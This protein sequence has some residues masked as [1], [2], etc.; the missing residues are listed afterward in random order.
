[1][2]RALSP[3]ALRPG[4]RVRHALFGVGTVL[5]VEGQGD[6]LKL[7]VSF[8]GIGA[9][10]LIARYA[11]L[12]LSEACA[13][14]PGRSR[15][16]PP[17]PLALGLRLL[18]D[19]AADHAAGPGRSAAGR[20]CAGPSRRAC[21]CALDGER[22]LDLLVVTARPA[23]SRSRACSRPRAARCASPCSAASLASASAFFSSR[24]FSLYLSHSRDLG[25]RLAGTFVSLR[26]PRSLIGQLRWLSRTY[27]LAAFLLPAICA[28]ERP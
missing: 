6:D 22:Q 27:W 19:P 20:T 7:T 11:G 14:L 28:V 3:G 8:S 23:G 9:K 10:R 26:W 15:R 4:V 1:M 21:G 17:S 13:P 12:E 18:D 16:L 2:S 5:R 24:S 25:C